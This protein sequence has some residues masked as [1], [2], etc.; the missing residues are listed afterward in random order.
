[1]RRAIEAAFA[2]IGVDDGRNFNLSGASLNSMQMPFGNVATTDEREF[3]VRSHA[4]LNNAGED[5]PLPL[6]RMPG[7]GVR[8]PAVGRDNAVFTR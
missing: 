4:W 1:M 2:R 3:Q 6:P 5:R 8:L 7:V